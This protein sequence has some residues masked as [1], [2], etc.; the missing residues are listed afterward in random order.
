[1]NDSLSLQ[2][3]AIDEIPPETLAFYQRVLQTLSEAGVPVLV[4]G[5]YAFNRYTAISRRTKDLDIF[6]RRGD[7]EAASESLRRHGYRTDMVYPHWLAKAYRGGESDEDDEDFVDIIF[8]SGNGIA[9]V[10]DLWFEHA[11]EDDVLGVRTK[12]CPIEEMIWSKAFVM[13]RERFDGADISHLLLACADRIDWQHL[14]QR[15]GPHW[16]VLLS[17]LVLFG[18][19]YPGHRES[20][21]ASLMEELLERLHDEI[22]VPP[23]DNAQGNDVC[24]GTLLSREQYLTD[25]EHWGYRDARVVPA[26]NMSLEDTARWTEAIQRQNQLH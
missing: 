9:A 14:R 6:I 4:G 23:Q 22:A 1:M 26:G 12:L 17:H 16:R 11:I 10:D 13:E 15:F 18:F 19:A 25:I 3:P 21:P 7:F 20:V 8:S 2:P 24:A 5:A